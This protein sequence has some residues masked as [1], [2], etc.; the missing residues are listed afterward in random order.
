MGGGSAN[1]GQTEGTPEEDTQSC[2][3]PQQQQEENDLPAQDS[4]PGPLLQ[5][6]H[7]TDDGEDTREAL[8]HDIFL[9][10]A[11]EGKEGFLV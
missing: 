10:P 3:P 1:V 4:A 9:A 5:V 11:N 8:F 2:D 6:M 7:V